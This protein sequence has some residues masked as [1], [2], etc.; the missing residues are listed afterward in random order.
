MTFITAVLE[1]L[2]AA[3][4]HIIAKVLRQK[5]QRIAQ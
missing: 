4:S 3:I 5:V 1:G 2:A